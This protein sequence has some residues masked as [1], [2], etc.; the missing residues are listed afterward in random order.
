M[1]DIVDTNNNNASASGFNQKS[2]VDE[3][4]IYVGDFGPD[5]TKESLKAKF[6]EYPSILYA[7]V[8]ID[9]A[10]ATSRGFGFVSFANKEDAEKAIAE[11]N[12]TWIGFSQIKVN[13]AN[14]K[15]QY[16]PKSN[17][18]REGG[19][20]GS[21][22]GMRYDQVYARTGPNNTSI[23]VGGIL[24]SMDEKELTEYFGKHGTITTARLQ[25]DRG[26]GF[27]KYATKDE[28]CRTIVAYHGQ[29]Y[30]GASLVVNWGK[31]SDSRGPRQN[32]GQFNNNNRNGQMAPQY[33]AQPQTGRMPYATQQTGANAAFMG[34]MSPY[35]VSAALPNS[36][37]TQQQMAAQLQQMQ[38][39]YQMATLLQQQQQQQQQAAAQTPAASTSAPAASALNA[40]QQAAYAAQLAQYLSAA[41]QQQPGTAPSPAAGLAPHFGANGSAMHK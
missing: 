12:A 39:M 29:V 14:R 8:M 22:F 5:V 25:T 19:S 34:Q 15:A 26:F 3:H 11:Q 33:Q 17:G 13:W 4:S 7:K 20:G 30:D 41:N 31:E 28:A 38:Q 2:R 32:G 18:P 35:G 9:P 37:Q 16:A 1:V 10:S 24:P 36:P 23:Y 21:G 40:Q 6:A 27:V